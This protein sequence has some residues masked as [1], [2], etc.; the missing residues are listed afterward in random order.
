[1]TL[2]ETTIRPGVPSVDAGR[3]GEG[4][5]PAPGGRRWLVV[6]ADDFGR[7]PGVTQGVIDAHRAGVVTSASLM[8]RWPGSEEAATYARGSGLGLGLH[9]DLGEWVHGPRGWEAVYE[10]VASDDAAAVADEVANQL[11]RFH[12]LLGRS[13]THIDSHQHVHRSE[14]ARSAVLGFARRLGI[15]VREVSS[16]IRY[17][18]GFYGQL[19]DGSPYPEGITVQNFLALLDGLE[20]GVTELSCHPGTAEADDDVYC[21]ERARELAVLCDPTVRLAMAERGVTPVSFAALA[22]LGP[23]AFGVRETS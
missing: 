3:S 6:N 21:S 19:G 7:T 20:P 4:A 15:P 11:G 17:C 2:Q 5:G 23:D 13:P 14:P 12:K 9:L 10:V 1:M 22:P 16:G 18:G 8:V